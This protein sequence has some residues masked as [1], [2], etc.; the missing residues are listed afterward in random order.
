[1]AIALGWACGAFASSSTW[2]QRALPTGTTTLTVDG[3]SCSGGVCVALTTP[4]GYEGCG[5]L[6]PTGVLRSIDGGATWASVSVPD[7]IS[8]ANP[9]GIG[10]FKQVSCW[11]ATGCVMDYER[12]PVGPTEA[13]GILYSADGGSTWSF[14]TVPGQAADVTGLSCQ[15]GGQCVAGLETSSG[16]SSSSWL[17]SSSDGGQTWGNETH[18]P[19]AVSSNSGLWCWGAHCVAVGTNGHGDSITASSSNGGVSWSVSRLPVGVSAVYDVACPTATTCLTVGYGHSVLSGR[20]LL[21]TTGGTSWKVVT[22]PSGTGI[23][24]GVACASAA[25][26]LTVGMQS[27]ANPVRTE[28]L[29]STNGGGQWTKQVLPRAYGQLDAVTCIPRG[30]CVATGQWLRYSGGKAIA[31]AGLIL[32]YR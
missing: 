8:D 14:A 9:D 30:R 3:V 1:L 17:L 13:G 23:Q 22:V 24:L 11:S 25:T 5:G 6:P 2:V 19:S 28:V 31:T 21:S 18:W 16:S 4:C 20:V 12:G 7:V 15:S 29:L 27:T 32:T 10:D 26:C